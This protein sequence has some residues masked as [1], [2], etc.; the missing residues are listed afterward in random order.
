MIAGQPSLTRSL[1]LNILV[2]PLGL[3]A[4][5]A[6][7]DT[8]TIGRTW[9]IVEPDALSEIEARV[10]RQPADIASK[11]GP[12]EGWSAMRAASLAPAAHS[13]VRT[14][15]PFHTLE[16]DIR[17]PDGRIVYPKGFTFNPL[18]Y[19]TLPQRLVV[20][21]P[22]DLAWAVAQARPTDFILLAAGNGADPI[23]L[24]EKAQR[25][26]FLLEPRVKERLDLTVAPVIVRQVGQ[27]LELTEV[28]LE[29]EGGRR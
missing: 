22:R 10:G 11:F 20:V 14:V 16:F 27:K 9:P 17:T 23:A 18:A 8:T 26:I 29:R 24:S 7:A 21:T 15:V 1:R 12:R 28:R 13:R 19:V 3:L 25:P 2:I 6:I 5:P 4:S